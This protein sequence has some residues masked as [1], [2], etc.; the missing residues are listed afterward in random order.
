MAEP[1]IRKRTRGAP[2]APQQKKP[3]AQSD[4]RFPASKDDKGGV[5]VSMKEYV[6][7]Q[8]LQDPFDGMYAGGNVAG[9]LNII[10]PPYNIY[11]LL[12]LPYENSIL[13]Q[14]ITA[15]V[16]NCV[17]HGWDLEFLGEEGKA[18]S[19]EA[20]AEKALIEKLLKYPNDDY[21]LQELR[22]RLRYDREASGN[23]YMEVG[24]DKARRVTML[25]HVPT[26]TVRLTTRD[27][28]E[29]AYEANLPRDGSDTST[30]KKRFRRFVQQVGEKKVYFK[31]Y[32]DPRKIDPRTGEVN[33]GL[34][35]EASA[36]AI[37]HYKIY[38]PTPP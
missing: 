2:A 6:P 9:P 35:W 33:D 8:T 26:Q 24:R 21:S 18:E 30:V 17:G 34:A 5:E 15:M 28:D 25:H 3:A 20:K 14:C 10:A 12:R 1:V 31:E 32:G 27:R 22:G 36:T 7:T 29:T 38:Y 4:R 37:I 11:A 23:A 16:E 13:L 19:Q